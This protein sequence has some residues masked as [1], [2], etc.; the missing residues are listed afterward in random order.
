[1]QKKGSLVEIVNDLRGFTLQQV[2][3][4]W[5][6]YLTDQ[7]LARTLPYQRKGLKVAV[8]GSDGEE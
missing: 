2:S 6:A 3:E 1:M 7:E 4:G 5:D 8:H